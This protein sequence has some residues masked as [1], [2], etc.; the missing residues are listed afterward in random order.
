VGQRRGIGIG[1]G[2]TEN[3]SP[4]F[5]VGLRPEKNQVLVGPYEA[6]ARDTV[7]VKDANWLCDI[8][9]GGVE[10]EVKLRSAQ[11]PLQATL[12]ADRVVLK[13]PAFGVAAGQAAVCYIGNRTLGGGWIS[14]A[15]NT[16][17]QAAA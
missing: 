7:F 2:H 4:L 15:E 6:L 14:R 16:K 10:V 3:N 11:A 12:Y 13:H 9:A 8:P 1:G 17:T 5:V